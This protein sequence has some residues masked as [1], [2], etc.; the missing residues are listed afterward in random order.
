VPFYSSIMYMYGFLNEFDSSLT[1]R[2]MEGVAN[3]G[4]NGGK[5]P[6]VVTLPVERCLAIR[7]RILKH[8]TLDSDVPQGVLDAWHR[9]GR[10][11]RPRPS[12]P[13][14]SLIVIEIV[15]TPAQS[16]PSNAAA[17]PTHT[18]HTRLDPL[19]CT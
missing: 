11:H 3:T 5:R 19:S 12:L 13:R 2:T 17:V 15:S 18:R 14:T 16:P 8:R 7:E 4:N 9:R 6:K 10:R 1:V